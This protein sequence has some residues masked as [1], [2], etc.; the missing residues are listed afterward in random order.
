MNYYHSH[1]ITFSISIQGYIF[2][3]LYYGIMSIFLRNTLPHNYQLKVFGKFREI[4]YLKIEDLL[5]NH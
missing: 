1:M 3:S 4:K 2:L 5:Y